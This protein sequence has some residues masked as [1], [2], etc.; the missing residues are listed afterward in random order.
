MVGCAASDILLVDLGDQLSQGAAVN[1]LHR[2]EMGTSVRSDGVHAHDIGV[3][4]HCGRLRFDLEP[5]QG[6][7]IQARRKRQH[8]QRDAA[9][10][11]KLFGFIHD[12]HPAPAQFTQDAKVTQYAARSIQVKTVNGLLA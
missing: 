11:R 7:G 1:Q 8:L 10:Q 2:I 6:F 12:S 9:S 5:L 3:F 4:Q